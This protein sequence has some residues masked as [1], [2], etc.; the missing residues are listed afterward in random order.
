MDVWDS[1]YNRW[2]QSAKRGG[3][4]HVHH[5][6]LG[7]PDREAEEELCTRELEAT[8]YSRIIPI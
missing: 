8:E 5:C 7:A 1:R 6:K 2:L 4:N 3:K